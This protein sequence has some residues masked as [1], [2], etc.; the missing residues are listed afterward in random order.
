MAAPAPK[1]FKTAPPRKCPEFDCYP[2]SARGL[3]SL[4]RPAPPQIY[5][6]RSF[7]LAIIL[8][9]VYNFTQSKKWKIWGMDTRG[10]N[11]KQQK[12]ETA[13][14]VIIKANYEK[15]H[16]PRVLSPQYSYSNFAFKWIPCKSFKNIQPELWYFVNHRR[17]TYIKYFQFFEL[18]TS[19]VVQ[20]SSNNRLFLKRITQSLRNAISDEITK[21]L[22]IS[23][24]EIEIV[25]FFVWRNYHMCVDA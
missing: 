20:P 25:L 14:H 2:A 4:P 22:K 13:N 19:C 7:I 17:K 15:I 10:G 6:L 9:I 18:T 11:F 21:F 8:E 24:S 3:Y 16:R 5:P 23:I 1:I 12:W